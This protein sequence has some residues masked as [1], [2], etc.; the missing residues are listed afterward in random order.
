MDKEKLTDTLLKGVHRLCVN[1]D[2]CSE[3]PFYKGKCMFDEPKPMT[4]FEDETPVVPPVPKPK[5]KEEEP[6]AKEPVRKEPDEK[7]K[8]R[9]APK[10][11]EDPTGTWL[12]STAMGSVFS[13][14]VYICSKC[15]YRKESVLSLTPMTLCPECEKRKKEQK[16]H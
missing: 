5:Q 4:W 3:C 16:E 9:E 10:V 15:G 7:P 14:Y 11:K 12:V 6:V 2:D 1:M 13:K 8:V